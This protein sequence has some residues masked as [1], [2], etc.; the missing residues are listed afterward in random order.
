MLPDGGNDEGDRPMSDDRIPGAATPASGADEVTRPAPAPAPEA[1]APEAPR[2]QFAAPEASTPAAPGPQLSV[3]EASAPVPDA[4]VAGAPV[5]PAQGRSPLATLRSIAVGLVFFFACLSLVVTTTAWW[6]DQTFVDTDGFVAAA[7]P[8]IDDPAVQETLAQSAADRAAE[9]LGLGEVGRYVAVGIARELF[10]SD[11]FAQVWE[12]ALRATH[13]VAIAVLRDEANVVDLVED[14]VV[15]NLYPFIDRILDRLAS[16]DLA[17]GGQPITLPVITDP[18]DPAASRAELEAFIGR[19]LPP[20][21]GTVPVAR[22]ERLV[23]AQYAFA[24]F[25][26]SLVVLLVVT[27]ALAVLAVVLARRRLR[28]IALLGVGGLASL[29]VARLVIAALED[30]VADAVTGGGDA[31]VIGREIIEALAG[32]YR[33]VTQVA[34]LLALV[35]AVVATVVAWA[36]SRRARDSGSAAEES[37]ADGWFLGIAGLCIALAALIL[38]GLTLGSFV[39]AAVAYIGWAV[40]IVRTRRKAGPTGAVGAG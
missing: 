32:S 8:I 3:P 25:E 7:A 4:P 14:Q 28:M 37:I 13:T 38:V 22:G 21:F 39:I 24:V 27:L 12:G 15:I 6:V 19:P 40:I 10:G 34:L 2:P 36:L 17:I 20:T 18:T 31:A 1:P 11:A 9:A 29:L 35:A 33:Q 23:A 5:A 16:L 26:T 30:A